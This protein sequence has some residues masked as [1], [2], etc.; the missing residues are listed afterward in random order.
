M[1]PDPE[2]DGASVWFFTRLGGVSEAPYESLNVSTKVGDGEEAVSENL[3]RIRSSMHDNETAWVRQQAGDRVYRVDAPGMAGEGDAL[4]S[5]EAGLSLVVAVA[6]C[7]PVAL[8]SRDEVGMVHSGWRGT[9]AG[10]SGNAVREMSPEPADVAAYI[11]PCIRGC[12]YEVSEEIAAD[13]ERRFGAGVAEGRYLSLPEAIK[14]NLEEAG[15]CEIHDLGLCTGCRPDLFYS[16]RKQKP[17]T[18]RNL[19][20]VA[21][22]V[23]PGNS[24]DLKAREA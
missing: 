13:F 16:H 21:R 22:A 9:L 14:R 10:V 11:G 20:A 12:C 3:A 23:E 24:G 4:V 8:A 19:T 2:P 1:T 6:D 17:T 5:S 15:V 18:G 7:V